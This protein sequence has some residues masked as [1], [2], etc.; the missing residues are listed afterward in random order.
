[1]NLNVSNV[2]VNDYNVY[3]IEDDEFVSSE[4]KR[5]KLWEEWIRDDIKKNINL[6]L[7]Y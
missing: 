3:F 1:M 7:I 4:L 5:G 6:V 2:Y